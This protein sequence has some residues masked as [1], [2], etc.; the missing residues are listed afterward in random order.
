MAIN[1]IQALLVALMLS[2]GMRKANQK[3][4]KIAIFSNFYIFLLAGLKGDKQNAIYD[5][6]FAEWYYRADNAIYV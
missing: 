5:I 2:A 1:N 3:R 4:N 6:K